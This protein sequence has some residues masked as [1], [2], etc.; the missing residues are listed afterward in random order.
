[1]FYNALMLDFSSGYLLQKF[2]YQYIKHIS[3]RIAFSESE[4]RCSVSDKFKI[5]KHRNSMHI[6]YLLLVRVL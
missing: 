1:M 3:V 6:K 5:D 2:S 4:N